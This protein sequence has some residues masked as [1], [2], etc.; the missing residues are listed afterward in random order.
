MS[1]ALKHACCNFASDA[2]ARFPRHLMFT[3]PGLTGVAG[4]LCLTLAVLFLLFT[5]ELKFLL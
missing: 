3:C 1:G 4:M 5:M 2:T